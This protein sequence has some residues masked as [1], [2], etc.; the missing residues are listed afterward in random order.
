MAQPAV[1]ALLSPRVGGAGRI[2]RNPQAGIDRLGVGRAVGNE[3]MTAQGHGD[4]AKGNARHAKEDV[5]NTFRH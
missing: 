2:D 1:G 4:Q 3:R 5:K